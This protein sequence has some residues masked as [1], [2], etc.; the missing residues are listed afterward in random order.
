MMYKPL[1]SD[2]GAAQPHSAAPAGGLLFALPPR[3]QSTQ[4]CRDES[5]VYVWPGFNKDYMQPM[6]GFR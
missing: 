6:R 4:S 3:S 5:H 2:T 1:A